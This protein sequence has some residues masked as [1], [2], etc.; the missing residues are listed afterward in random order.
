MYL[1]LQE[2]AHSVVDHATPHNSL[3]NTGEVVV[4][5]NNIASLLRNFVT[6]DTHAETD[7]GR[8]ESRTVVCTITRNT[9]NLAEALERV[10]QDALIFWA[11]T[12]E[13]L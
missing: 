2:L 4:H 12:S 11:R 1:E 6:R 7:I 9:D 5:K 3:D 13:N 8:L 10:D